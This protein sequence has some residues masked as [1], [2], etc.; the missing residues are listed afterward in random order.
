[1][2]FISPEFSGGMFSGNISLLGKFP[3]QEL[4]KTSAFFPH[5]SGE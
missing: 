2:N 4:I 3:L 5:L 1:M